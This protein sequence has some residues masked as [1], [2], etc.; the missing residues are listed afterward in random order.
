MQRHVCTADCNMTYQRGLLL[1]LVC[2]W[3]Y[4]CTDT[5]ARDAGEEE[6][7]QDMEEDFN[8]STYFHPRVRR[9]SNRICVHGVTAKQEG[10][11]KKIMLKRV[12]SCC[13]FFILYEYFSFFS[14]HML[15]SAFLEVL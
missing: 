3:V 7:V 4:G 9:L 6:S 13:A 10:G 1:L 12:S 15:S 5:Y 8:C 14:T 11:Q 2:V